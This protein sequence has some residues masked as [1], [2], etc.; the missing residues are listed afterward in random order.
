MDKSG[1]VVAPSVPAV[2]GGP[3]WAVD[4]EVAKPATRL[5]LANWMVSQDNPLTARDPTLADLFE[6]PKI[7]DNFES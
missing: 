1:E 4:G 2:L 6:H 3:D 5:D 7:A